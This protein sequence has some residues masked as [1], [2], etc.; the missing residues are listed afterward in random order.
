MTEP[1]QRR[2]GVGLLI[3][4]IAF[5]L[6]TVWLPFRAGYSG[7]ARTWS[8]VWLGAWLT[9]LVML[10][11]PDDPK[12]RTAPQPTVTEA[13]PEPSTEPDAAVAAD[14]E[15]I[16]AEALDAA[17]KLEAKTWRIG[18]RHPGKDSVKIVA[19]RTGKSVDEVNDAVNLVARAREE[20]LEK[21]AMARA[22]VTGQVD[23]QNVS[24]SKLG[25]FTAMISVTVIGC[26]K[27]GLP[28]PKLDF[29]AEE[30]MKTLADEMPDGVDGYKV[31]LWYKG[32]LCGKKSMGYG[33]SW[34][35]KTGRITLK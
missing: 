30:A 23:T 13:A 21:V 7:K 27:R 1:Q 29:L 33:A 10:A 19:R 3:G 4:I 15:P 11:T 2:V 24:R 12:P 31:S 16:T 26:P 22:E 28:D 5:P 17:L 35:R 14:E 34:S 32:L 25:P 9:G 20:L 8:C 6:A 18:Q